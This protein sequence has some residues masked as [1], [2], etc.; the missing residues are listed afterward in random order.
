[1]LRGDLNTIRIGECTNIQDGAMVHVSRRN[2]VHVGNYVSIGH[3]VKLH[4]CSVGDNV[5]VGIG[6]VILDGAKIG[7]N[8]LISASTVVSENAKIPPGSLVM[9]IPGK[10]RRSLTRGEKEAIRGSAESHLSLVERYRGN[11]KA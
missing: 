7:D 8:C 3:C 4:G 5:L 6:A 9:G 1:M 11:G 2:P 10:V